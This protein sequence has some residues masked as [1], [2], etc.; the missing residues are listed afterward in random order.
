MVVFSQVSSVGLG[1]CLRFSTAR[2][3][4]PMISWAPSRNCVVRVVV[5]DNGSMTAGAFFFLYRGRIVV[6]IPG[7]AGDTDQVFA[8]A[9]KRFGFQIRS[10][11]LTGKVVLVVAGVVRP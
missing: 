4:I 2:R 8:L 1:E 5:F 9:D 10:T 6:R 11:Q 7:A 3:T